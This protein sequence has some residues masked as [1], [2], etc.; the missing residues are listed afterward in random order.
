M[1]PVETQR[2]TVLIGQY[3]P[4]LVL[5]ARQWCSDPEDAVQEACIE[6]TKLADPPLDPIAWLYTTTK[7]RA[8]N[9]TRGDVRR[10]NRNVI[11]GNQ[12]QENKSTTAATAWFISD[13]EIREQIEK[14]QHE[15]ERLEPL[16]REIV[17]SHLWGGLTFV[18]IGKLVDRSSSSV[19][20]YYQ[21]ALIK[22]RQALEFAPPKKLKA[23][24]SDDIH[25]FRTSL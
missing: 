6:M 2:L 1:L 16:E 20:R 14:L 8:M 7:R 3:G 13:L 5:Y 4:S 11:A 21:A 17:V 19:H 15:L 12:A 22:L 10:R 24:P 25:F 23:E 18:Q 9:Q